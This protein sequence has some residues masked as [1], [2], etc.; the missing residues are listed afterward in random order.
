MKNITK[1]SRVLSISHNDMDGVGCQILLANY[2]RNIAFYNW[3]YYDIDEKFH[4]VKFEDWDL[5]I[6][7]DLSPTNHDLLKHP[8]IVYLDHHESAIEMHSPENNR[9]VDL[10]KCGTKIVSEWLAQNFTFDDSPFWSLVDYINDYDMWILEYEQSWNMNCLFYKYKEKDFYERFL[11]G[12][13]KFTPEEL[14]YIQS[15]KKELDDTFN[16]LDTMDIPEINGVFFYAENFLNDLCHRFLQNG[17]DYSFCYNIK[18]NT[19]SIR[20][21]KELN[22][23]VLL[24]ELGVGGGHKKAAGTIQTTGDETLELLNKIKDGILKWKLS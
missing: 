22:L 6:I 19:I 24:R 1:D 12:D 4:N 5:I 17:Y 2:F 16:G 20:T 3:S 8:K 11:G 23:G 15:Q 9:I 10:S 18:R 13:T 14:E 21:Q 7:S